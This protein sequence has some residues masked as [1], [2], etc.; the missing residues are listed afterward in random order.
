M[1]AIRLI[2]ELLE[3]ESFEVLAIMVPGATLVCLVSAVRLSLWRGLTF[4]DFSNPIAFVLCAFIA[5]HALQ[6]LGRLLYHR[7]RLERF[8]RDAREGVAVESLKRL[9]QAVLKQQMNLDVDAATA[10]SICLSH[11]ESRR[12]IY[13]KFTALR[14]MA[15]GLA[16][17][18]LAAAGLVA[19]SSRA[20][21]YPGAGRVIGLGILGFLV[22]HELYLLFEHL[23][24]RSVCAQYL[25]S[26]GPPHSAHGGCKTQSDA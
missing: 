2:V 24:E 25:D 20:A 26:I 5:G 19:A 12:T 10:I 8:L 14:D 18:S 15:R 9:V 7:L 6:G 23:P 3:K 4:P 21:A 22:F 17:A 1:D 16:T 11:V 13:D